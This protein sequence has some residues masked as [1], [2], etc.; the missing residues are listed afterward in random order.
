MKAAPRWG[1]SPWLADAACALLPAEALGGI[2]LLRRL[3][4]R[5]AG[6]QPHL[7]PR[8]G[9]AA[10]PLHQNSHQSRKKPELQ[11]RHT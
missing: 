3:R 11:T 2:S 7:V 5:G 1:G 6:A 9:S 8:T 4:E 10:A